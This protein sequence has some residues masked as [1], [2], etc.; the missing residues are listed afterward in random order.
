MELALAGD[1]SAGS[2]ALGRNR[3]LQNF[4]PQLHLLRCQATCDQRYRIDQHPDN[5]RTMGIDITDHKH[6]TYVPDHRKNPRRKRSAGTFSASCA[7]Q[8][9]THLHIAQQ[10]S[11]QGPEVERC[12]PQLASQG[13]QVPEMIENRR[14]AT[15]NT[16]Q[17]YSFL[18]RRTDSAFNQVVLRRLR[19]SKMHRHVL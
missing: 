17:L 11:P 6:K 19:M 14:R 9:N 7:Y 5:T 12:L 3:T 15:A 8:K 1:G 16:S 10:R 2:S 4:L 18:A 13:R